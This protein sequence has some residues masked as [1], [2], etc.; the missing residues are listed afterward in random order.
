MSS[1]RALRPDPH[2]ARRVLVVDDDLDTV[3]SMA[4]LIKT[5]GHYVQFAINGTAAIN[6]AREFRPE[7]VLLDYRLPDYNGDQVA[8]QI[9]SNCGLEKVRIIAI[10]GRSQDEDRRRS[11][12]EGCEDYRVKPLDPIV[13]EALLAKP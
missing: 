13:L 7:I 2:P 12:A 4:M 11:L 5:M 10:T 1:L 6:I 3:H 8:K 9:K